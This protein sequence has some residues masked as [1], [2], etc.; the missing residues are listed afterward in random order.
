MAARGGVRRFMLLGWGRVAS[1]GHSK[2]V[3]RLAPT[4]PS[5]LVARPLSTS[6][7]NRLRSEKEILDWVEKEKSKG[8]ESRGIF[9]HDKEADN[10][11]YHMVTFLTVATL[12]FLT[13]SWK[14]FPDI[15]QRNWAMREAY[16]ILREREAKGQDPICKDFIDPA[17]IEL[18]SEEELE[19]VEIVI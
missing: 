18:P 19:G 10:Q 7:C 11:H 6:A 2:A 12:V 17:K 14:Y 9:Y 3:A 8:W 15:R 4:A 16:L 5:L 13:W 1:E